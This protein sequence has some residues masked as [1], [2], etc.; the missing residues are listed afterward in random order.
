MPGP[1]EQL[2]LRRRVG[3]RLVERRI[4]EGAVLLEPGLD[5]VHLA[6]DPS[7]VT[8][9]RTADLLLVRF[10]FQ[11]LRFATAEGVLS[12]QRRVAERP[13]YLLVDFPPQHLVEEAFAEQV[14]P[15]LVSKPELPGGKAF[16]PTAEPQNSAANPP[17]PP[18]LANLGE[19]SR[20]AYTVTDETIPWSLEGLLGAMS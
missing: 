17:A 13:G 7:P 8:A 18:V 3:G 20:L 6:F 2:A 9:L 12:L 16:P 19:H 10:S 1:N 11:N 5:P 4:D 15:K 14:D